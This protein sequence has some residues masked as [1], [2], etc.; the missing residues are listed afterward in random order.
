MAVLLQELDLITRMMGTVKSMMMVTMTMARLEVETTARNT[1]TFT[2]Q[3][4][5]WRLSMKKV[6][7]ISIIVECLLREELVRSKEAVVAP[8]WATSRQASTRCSQQRVGPTTRLIAVTLELLNAAITVAGHHAEVVAAEAAVKAT[9][10]FMVETEGAG[11]KA[12][13]HLNTTAIL[14]V[15]RATTITTKGAI[16]RSMTSRCGAASPSTLETS[17]TQVTVDRCVGV[18]HS[19]VDA[20]MIISATSQAVLG[21]PIPAK[22]HIM[23]TMDLEVLTRHSVADKAVGGPVVV[24]PIIAAVVTTSTMLVATTTEAVVAGLAEEQLETAVTHLV[25][26]K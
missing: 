5:K 24:E 3:M 11:T 7:T 2:T 19:I 18:T 4:I 21:S 13:R 15:V 17:T 26:I 10:T 20:M 14:A 1:T 16:C 12:M 9:N 8:E 6:P 25:V 23:A 22:D